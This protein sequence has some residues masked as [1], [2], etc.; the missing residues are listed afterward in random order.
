MIG[1][2]T[3]YRMDAKKVIVAT[4]N[5]AAPTL[6]RQGAYMRGIAKRLIRYRKNPNI[7]APAGSPP[8]THKG[9][10]LKRSIIFGVTENRQSVLIGPT[11][12]VIGGIGATHE[13]GGIEGPKTYKR[14]PIR[15]ANWKLK[16]GG[17]G[18]IRFVGGKF[19]FAKLRTDA[20]VSRASRLARYASRVPIKTVRIGS[21]TYPRRPFMGPALTIA[22]S[23]LPGFWRGAV[24]RV[25]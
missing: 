18:P 24:R 12:Q 11:A 15:R 9:Q 14:D 21:R 3:G 5:A 1:M 10:P 13:W 25:A 19:Y 4:R 16:I 8:Y 20:Q 7:N 17:H 23:R 2:K 22:L 6:A